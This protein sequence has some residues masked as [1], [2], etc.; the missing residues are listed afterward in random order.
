[1]NH[2]TETLRALIYKHRLEQKAIAAKAGVSENTM[3]NILKGSTSTSV[4]TLDAVL[5]ACEELVPGFRTQYH[6]ALLGDKINLDEF[7]N[8]LSSNELAIV[9]MNI[10][11]RIRKLGSRENAIAA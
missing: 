6:V 10:G 7:V 3:S 2:Y 1:M 8:S 4:K 11:Q 5:D 9:M